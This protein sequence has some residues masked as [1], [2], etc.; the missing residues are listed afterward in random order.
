MNAQQK[1]SDNTTLAKA[2]FSTSL[3]VSVGVVTAHF[4]LCV[5]IIAAYTKLQV[6]ATAELVVT[7]NY[8]NKDVP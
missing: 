8:Q 1:L 4:P 6:C 5:L 3:N 2:S 7:V